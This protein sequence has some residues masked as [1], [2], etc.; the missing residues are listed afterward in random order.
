MKASQV[1]DSSSSSRTSQHSSDD[2]TSRDIS[3]VED[4]SRPRKPS[5]IARQRLSTSQARSQFAGSR[6]DARDID[7]SDR[8]TGG[9]RSYRVPAK[10]RSRR[11]RV[12][13]GEGGY[14][15]EYEAG[16]DS[17]EE[18][19]EERIARL[20]REVEEVKAASEQRAHGRGSNHENKHDESLT[21]L[22]EMLN[23]LQTQTRASR[24]AI[25]SK[26]DDTA[27]RT[28]SGSSTNTTQSAPQTTAEADLTRI[29]ASAS[30]LESR[31]TLL[32]YALGLPAL[33]SIQPSQPPP[34]RNV[35]T[36]LQ[37]L[38]T[39]LTSLT[40][41]TLPSLETM[42]MQIQTL[43]TSTNRLK[44]ARDAANTAQDSGA[45][46][47]PMPAPH[48]RHTTDGVPTAT[49]NGT[50]VLSSE[51]QPS[52]TPPSLS[53]H[54]DTNPDLTTRINHLHALLPT[55]TNLSP[56]LPSLLDRLKSLRVLHADAATMSERFDEAERLQAKLGGEI[57]RWK[58]ALK[59]FEGRLQGVEEVSE[60]N[61]ARV[62]GWVRMLE[63]RL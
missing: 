22:G 51:T 3:S 19:L 26:T 43:T 30:T 1:T 45:V 60:G 18:S 33:S 50:T 2:E 59:G 10:R 63:G 31:L 32:E 4:G 9:R 12:E 8:I 14:V 44:E 48:G 13:N 53:L 34:P 7:F 39:Q 56:L 25:Q 21:E 58:G 57:E 42:T 28:T 36:T 61:R 40:T 35:L 5:R 24:S 6:V 47:S 23:T 62:E 17:D 41:T 20:K 11:R 46:I 52:S 49:T 54:L 37:K 15:D 16:T 38:E 29:F 55:L 27:T